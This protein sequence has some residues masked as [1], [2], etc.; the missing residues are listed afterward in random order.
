MATSRKTKDAAV[1]ESARWATLPDGVNWGVRV[2]GVAVDTLADKEIEVS[3]RNGSK[4]PVMLGEL[5]QAW[6]NNGKATYSVVRQSGG[7]P[8]PLL[9]EVTDAD[10]KALIEDGLVS[11]GSVTLVLP[12]TKSNWCKRP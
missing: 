8:P 9:I 11:V 4:S 1:I 10:L 3:R 6:D 12:A 2:E 5:I 7:K